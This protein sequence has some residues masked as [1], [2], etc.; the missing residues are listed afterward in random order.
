MR[1]IKFRADK[2]TPEEQEENEQARAEHY[3]EFYKEKVKQ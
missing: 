1:E 3:E 2:M